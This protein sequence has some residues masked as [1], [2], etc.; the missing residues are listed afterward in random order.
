M[1]DTKEG[2]LRIHSGDLFGAL[3][4]YQGPFLI[5]HVCNNRNG[6]GQ[7]FVQAID[8]HYPRQQ[9]VYRRVFDGNVSP[10]VLGTVAFGLDSEAGQEA[11]FAHMI[12]QD[13]YRS[14][15]NPTPLSYPMLRQCL[16]RVAEYCQDNGITQVLAPKMG[17]GLAGG[18]WDFICRMLTVWSER[19]HIDID[20]YVL[21][22]ATT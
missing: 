7:G 22:P 10:S 14:W 2:V 17:A 3:A 21:D 4:T 9:H 20:V 8:Q 11:H 5:M 15:R 12:C 1:S 18:D 19:F 16:I 13:G 6:W